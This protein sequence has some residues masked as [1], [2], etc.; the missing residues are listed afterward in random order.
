MS[1]IREM[2]DAAPAGSAPYD[3]LVVGGGINGCGIA[4]DAAGRGARVL[5]V[6][7][8]DL[9]S[10]TSSASTKLI[11]GGLRYLEYYEFRLVREALIER[12]RLLRIAPHIIWPMRFVLPHSKLVRPAWLLRAGLFLYDHLCPRMSLPKTRALNFRKDPTGRPLKDD[13]TRGFAYSDGWVQDSRLVALNAMDAAAHGAEIRTRTKLVNA[14]RR[15]DIWE[16]TIE[17]SDTGSTRTVRAK[18]IVNAAGPW[19]A[20]LLQD[21]VHVASRNKVR[22]VKGSHIVVPK[23]FEGT[24]AY[25]LQNPDKRIVFAIPY[26]GRFTLIGTTDV[27]WEQDAGHVEISPEEV[28]YLCDSVNR[29]FKSAI[30]ADDVVWTYAGVRP[31]YDDNSG[32]ASAV[33]RDYVLDVDASAAP[34][35]S[36]FGGKITTFRK[37]AEHALEKLAPHLPV[38]NKPE[39][40]ADKPLPGGDF[41]GRQFK[42]LV[43]RLQN[44]APHLDPRTTYRLARNYGTRAFDIATKT[45]EEMGEDFGAGLTQR[46]VDY[47][48]DNEWARSAEDILWRRSKLGLFV[49]KEDATRIQDYIARRNV[50]SLSAQTKQDLEWRQNVA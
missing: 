9:A 38:L 5:L 48:I 10:H 13:Y 24:Q 4:R 16:A 32:S 35:L 21:K 26:E 31:L 11:H 1:S 44:H 23:M 3:L 12:E 33:T 22:L 14:K 46:E 42:A 20:E 49:S 43:D 15:A 18:A 50:P 2:P 36:V 34:I 8:H 41:D 6:E 47:L 28:T 37:L 7:Q 25:I 29:Y 39:W 27:A 45:I 19:V 40:T 30:T 17:N